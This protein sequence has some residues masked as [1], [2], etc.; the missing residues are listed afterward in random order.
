MVVVNFLGFLLV[1]VGDAPPKMQELIQSSSLHNAPL[2][3]QK[4]Q[5]KTKKCYLFPFVVS[6]QSVDAKHR[7][8]LPDH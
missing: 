3:P 6:L 5:T 8:T 1:R 2:G 4:Y 7:P